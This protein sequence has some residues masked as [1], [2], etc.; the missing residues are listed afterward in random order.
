MNTAAQSVAGRL[1]ELAGIEPDSPAVLVER[2]GLWHSLT[3]SEVVDQFQKLSTVLT[4]HGVTSGSRVVAICGDRSR[5]VTVDLALQWC[6]A[7]ALIVS[8]DVAPALCDYF[9][10][11]TAPSFVIVDRDTI[12]GELLAHVD[13]FHASGGH[14][15]DLGQLQR[16]RLEALP[17]LTHDDSQLGATLT[18]SSGLTA[19]RRL[20]ELTTQAVL[21]ASDRAVSTLR[22]NSRD[23]CIVTQPIDDASHR[24]LS[25]YGGLLS[26]AVVAFPDRYGDPRQAMRDVR[27]TVLTMSP[28]ELADLADEITSKLRRTRLMKRLLV[29]GLL[30]TA[31][32]SETPS[33]SVVRILAARLVRSKEGWTSLRLILSTG[34][35]LPAAVRTFY[36]QLGIAVVAG[37][38]YADLPG[39][40]LVETGDGAIDLM[41]PAEGVDASIGSEGAMHVRQANGSLLELGDTFVAEGSGWRWQGRVDRSIDRW[42]GASHPEAIEQLACGIAVVRSAVFTETAKGEPRLIVEPRLDALRQIAKADGIT[43]L[44]DGRLVTDKRVREAVRDLVRFTLVSAGLPSSISSS[45]DVHLLSYHVDR[46]SGALTSS[47]VMRPVSVIEAFEIES[48]DAS[49]S[50]L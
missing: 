18:L 39:L 1:V 7:A 29:R 26:G 30:K 37:M 36:S 38:S 49:R 15:L 6:N 40:A 25:T 4:A 27:P 3:R 20:V 9:V 8:D 48:R 2:L 12:G 28:R 32:M 23:R 21:D 17:R 44:S 33:R 46:S 5:A 34:A 22:M 47:G 35:S 13:R 11:L 24:T 14:V 50:P 16:E 43:A 42:D 41:K 45:I 31:D 19:R 10:K